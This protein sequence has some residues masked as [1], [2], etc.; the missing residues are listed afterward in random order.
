MSSIAEGRFSVVSPY[1]SVPGL[2]VLLQD[3]VLLQSRK[4]QMILRELFSDVPVRS[5]R[6]LKLTSAA[7]RPSSAGQQVV[8][9]PAIDE[10]LQKKM[11]LVFLPEV[12]AKARVEY[13][14]G[15]RWA[16]AAPNPRANSQWR[17]ALTGGFTYE[18]RGRGRRQVERDRPDAAVVLGQ[19]VPSP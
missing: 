12:P 4:L 16:S 17:A 18:Q 11:L 6:E 7:S 9:L 2:P 1:P 13:T 10:G 5:I 8:V 15:W 3:G 14:F 19:L